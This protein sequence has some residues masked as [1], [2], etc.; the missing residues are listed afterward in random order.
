[1]NTTALIAQE[2]LQMGDEATG[3]SGRGPRCSSRRPPDLRESLSKALDA[4]SDLECV[5]HAQD[6]AEAITAVCTRPAT[7]RPDVVLM[8]VHL[9]DRDGISMMAELVCATTR[10]SR[11]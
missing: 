8:D 10:T 6:S 4:E 5:G 9:P 11:S 2:S 3:P 7:R 1:M